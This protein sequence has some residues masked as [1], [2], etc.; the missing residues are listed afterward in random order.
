MFIIG[1]DYVYVVQDYF[2]SVTVVDNTRHMP[3][4][5]LVPYNMKC[6]NDGY[7]CIC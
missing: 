6:D 4:V 2:W 3:N 5:R 1:P 7:H